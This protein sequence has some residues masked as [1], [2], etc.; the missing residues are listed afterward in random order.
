LDGD[1]DFFRTAMSVGPYDPNSGS[2]HSSSYLQVVENLGNSNFQIRGVV[3]SLQGFGATVLADFDA[4]GDSDIAVATYG[5][6]NPQKNGKMLWNNGNWF[7]SSEPLFDSPYAMSLEGSDYDSDGDLDLLVSG[8]FLAKT[9]FLENGNSNPSNP[10]PPDNLSLLTS[11]QSVVF[12]W[13]SHPSP[14]WHAYNVFIRKDN[15]FV[16][17]PQADIFSGSSYLLGTANNGKIN[18]RTLDLAALDEGYYNWSVQAVNPAL[19]SSIFAPEREFTVY[20][21]NS[22]GAPTGLVVTN[23]SIS[24]VSLEWNDQAPDE[25][26]Y[27]VERAEISGN[28]TF[29]SIVTLGANAESFIDNSLY[30]NHVYY[31]RVRAVRPEV[32]LSNIVRAKTLPYLDEKPFNLTAVS[33]A[34]AKIVLSWD[35]DGSNNEGFVV[36]RSVDNKDNFTAVDTLS[37]GTISFTDIGLDAMRNYFYRVAAFHTTGNSD[38]SNIASATTPMQKFQVGDISTLDPEKGE[39]SMSWGDY[40]ND[41]FDDLFLSNQTQLFK[42]N[43]DGSF[44]TIA[45]SGISFKS[46]S[47]FR[48]NSA[49]GDYDND[50]YLDIL[51]TNSERENL[52]FHSKGDGTFEAITCA[53]SLSNDENSNITWL[54][55]DNDGDLDVILSSYYAHVLSYYR[56][57]GNNIFT[58]VNFAPNDTYYS[59]NNCVAVVDFDAN[60][61]TD[62]F[63]GNNGKDALVKNNYPADFTLV[64]DS[65]VISD[66]YYECCPIPTPY[67]AWS[68]FNNDLFPDLTVIHTGHYDYIYKG[69]PDGLDSANAFE[70]ES[71]L[72]NPYIFWEDFDNDGDVDLVNLIPS[73]TNKIFENIGSGVLVERKSG[74]LYNQLSNYFALSWVDYDNDGFRDL[75]T[76][77]S[78]TANGVYK[79][80]SN[81]NKWLKIRLAGYASNSKGVGA[82]I[83]LKAN[84]KWQRKDVTTS[85]SYH[86]QQGF[87]TIFGLRQANI[88]D[89]IRVEWPSG[90][91]QTLTLVAPEQIITIR[92]SE[93]QI[94]PLYKPSNLN[95]T[96]YPFTTIKLFWKDNSGDEEGFKIQKSEDGTNYQDLA[97]LESDTREF[98]VSNLKI[99]QTYYLRVAAYKGAVYSDWSNIYKGKITL[100]NNVDVG[101]LTRAE[102]ESHGVSWS[103]FSGDGMADLFVISNESTGDALYTNSGTGIFNKHTAFVNISTYSRAGV[104]GDFDNDGLTDLFVAV[105]G[106]IIGSDYVLHDKLYKNTGNGNF[107]NLS[108]DPVATDGLGSQVGAWGDLNKDGYIDLVVS[109]DAQLLTYVNNQGMGFQPSDNGGIDY[110]TT[111]LSLSDFDSDN[112]LDLFTVQQYGDLEIWENTNGA[113]RTLY[114]STRFNRT[115]GFCLDDFDGDGDFDLVTAGDGARFYRFDSYDKVFKEEI[116]VFTDDSGVYSSCTA[117]DFDNNGLLDVLLTKSSTGGVFYLNQSD[118]VFSKHFGEE[119]ENLKGIASAAASDYDRDGDVDLFVSNPYYPSKNYIMAANSTPNNWCEVKLVG[120]ASNRDGIGAKIKLIDRNQNQLREVRTNSG[121]YS[122]NEQIAHFGLGNAS[123]VEYLKIEWPSGH[124]QWVA[125]PA[126][127]TLLTIEEGEGDDAPT[128]TVGP[129]NL[130][131]V[132][133]AD[134]SVALEWQDHSENETSFIVERSVDGSPYRQAARLPSG[135][136]SYTDNYFMSPHPEHNVSYRVAAAID[137]IYSAY[138]NEASVIVPITGV[139]NP[140]HSLELYPNPAEKIIRIRSSVPMDEIKIFDAK[141]ILVYHAF[142]EQVDDEIEI[143]ITNFRNGIFILQARSGNTMTSHK[144]IIGK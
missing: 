111:L 104:W 73:S 15:Q 43:G 68:D 9:F 65:R 70:G 11:G 19:K 8:V 10:E 141:G 108:T 127:N 99:G 144:V 86:V 39:T 109:T 75:I 44:T 143:M 47:Y 1:E 38:Y 42:N 4:D 49:W 106:N 23:V 133:N 129:S 29:G 118:G 16:I 26:G 72:A 114:T 140:T 69:G 58:L 125:N 32:S 84:G 85:H 131:T 12:S 121:S 82:K 122:A 142:P 55:M 57:D 94:Q 91:R 113:F 136:T 22:S 87:E 81:G 52:L 33:T 135:S 98:T 97:T 61:L 13:D 56:Y 27:V 123:A 117:A 6:S 101:F 112:D 59:T 96:V 120:H 83:Y 88:V 95:G 50:G 54:D 30:S 34:A 51:I 45:N 64:P 66:S 46:S 92:E 130:Q 53:I 80:I 20:K 74:V 77:R 132:L 40:D 62:I 93:A 107:V 67:A 25:T 41:G 137:D 89:S 35:Y 116:V 37:V 17:T 128:P 14:P 119:I 138:S 103:D 71:G 102:L 3:D 115:G 28:E 105:G 110:A 5:G 76:L 90:A 60:G 78:D 31:Y 126:I 24:T 36:Y 139:E 100:F 48:S 134:M 18:Q 7:F 21:N 124:V 2:A 79:N 63:A